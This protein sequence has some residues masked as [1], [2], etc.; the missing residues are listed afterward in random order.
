MS[1]IKPNTVSVS[2]SSYLEH[3]PDDPC[4]G[5]YVKIHCDCGFSGMVDA[6]DDGSSLSGNCE[7]CLSQ[8]TQSM[9]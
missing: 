2:M 5:G 3:D 9:F 8:F 1:D 6:D 4:A 7:E